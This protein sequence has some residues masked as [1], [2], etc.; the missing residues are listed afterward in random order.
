VGETVLRWDTAKEATDVEDENL[1]KVGAQLCWRRTSGEA[2]A[3][4]V[5]RQPV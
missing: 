4:G 2:V 5:A 1:K 3:R